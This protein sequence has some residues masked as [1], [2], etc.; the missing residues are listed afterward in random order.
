MKLL[1]W[2]GAAI[3]VLGLLSL[4]VPISHTQRDGMSAGG[5]S[6]GVQ[7]HYDE[8]VSPFVSGALVLAG[9]GMMVAGRSAVRA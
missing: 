9:A 3:I 5:I 1:F 2:F 4:V 7:T 8:R 6:V